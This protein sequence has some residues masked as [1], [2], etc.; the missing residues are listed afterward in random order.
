MKRTRIEH[1][2][3]QRLP[4]VS[5]KLIKLP[6]DVVGYVFSF[7]NVKEH[8]CLSYTCTHL[9]TVSHK[10][11][12]WCTNFILSLPA[13]DSRINDQTCFALRDIDIKKLVLENTSAITA[14]GIVSLLN[15]RKSAVLHAKHYVSEQLEHFEIR[16][17]MQIS[18]E[19]IYLLRN[20]PLKVFSAPLVRDFRPICM[21][22]FQH[23]PLRELKLGFM[24]GLTDD[25]F[26]HL[27]TCPLEIFHLYNNNGITLKC[28]KWLNPSFLRE[29]SL[30][31]CWIV[32]HD[33]TVLTRFPALIRLTLKSLGGVSM[34]SSLSDHCFG[35][36]QEYCP[37]IQYLNLFSRAFKGTQ[38][39]RLLLYECLTEFVWTIQRND[40]LYKPANLS[41]LKKN[42]RLK[43]SFDVFDPNI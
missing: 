19:I 31:K 30:N 38:L 40:H 3:I 11:G 1:Q 18:T 4:I 15:L 27:Q 20:R 43:Y 10:P 41:I 24:S 16:T 7:L 5:F 34:G 42:P 35:L 36:L 22:Y 37:Q 2:E 17:Q 28:L 6:D 14:T 9:Q 8:L 32:D 25:D 21:V 29:I 26:K 33:L 39:H 12:S 23:M 13:P